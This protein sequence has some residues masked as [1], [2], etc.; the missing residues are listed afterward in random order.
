MIT[1]HEHNWL[2]FNFEFCLNLHNT[3]KKKENLI[4]MLNFAV[5]ILAVI[6]GYTFRH[7]KSSIKFKVIDCLPLV[8]TGA[9]LNKD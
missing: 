2:N 1:S 9:K 5:I 7:C 6:C 3:R 4:I 8:K